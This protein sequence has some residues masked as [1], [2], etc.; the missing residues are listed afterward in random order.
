MFLKY[1]FYLLAIL[2]VCY[3]S[4]WAFNHINPW[5]GIGLFVGLLIFLGNKIFNLCNKQ[6]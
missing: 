1:C 6:K 2:A 3:G 5:L 4:S